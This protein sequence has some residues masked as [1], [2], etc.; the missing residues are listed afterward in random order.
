MPSL[1]A[2]S[3]ALGRVRSPS[4]PELKDHSPQKRGRLGTLERIYFALITCR[5]RQIS[6]LTGDR[7]ARSNQTRRELQSLRTSSRLPQ[8]RPTPQNDA[9]SRRL[10]PKLFQRAF[11]SVALKS[12]SLRTKDCYPSSRCPSWTFPNARRNDVAQSKRPCQR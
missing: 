3:S 9:T 8:G 1:L 4:G 5:S 7:Q 6:P 10:T 12:W 11:R 2:L